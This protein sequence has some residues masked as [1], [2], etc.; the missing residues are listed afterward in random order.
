M[1]KTKPTT[2]DNIQKSKSPVVRD[3]KKVHK[4]ISVRVIVDSEIGSQDKKS[5]I[6]RP[7]NAFMIFATEWR[8]K[9]VVEHPGEATL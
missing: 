6:P 4:D 7:P 2:S 1:L 8:K 3:E 5:E 9:I